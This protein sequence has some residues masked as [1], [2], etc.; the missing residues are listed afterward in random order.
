[1]IYNH[2]LPKVDLAALISAPH[3]ADATFR[4]YI[5]TFVNMR[6]FSDIIGNDIQVYHFMALLFTHG[7]ET[8]VAAAAVLAEDLWNISAVIHI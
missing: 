6:P 5:F 7:L 2:V 4:D 1:M 3:W 8:D